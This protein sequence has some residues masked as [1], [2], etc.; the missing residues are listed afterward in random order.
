[1]LLRAVRD[2]VSTSEEPLGEGF[3][4]L[5]AQP[6]RVSATRG[7]PTTEALVL[8]PDALVRV[9]GTDGVP[10]YMRADALPRDATGE[11]DLTRF[12]RG[13]RR[14]LGG[15]L[16]ELLELTPLSDLA[17]DLAVDAAVRVLESRLADRFGL[18]RLPD[19]DSAP[20]APSTWSA[21]R[22]DADA[23]DAPAL[24][25]LH[26]V[27]QLPSQ[28]FGALAGTEAWRALRHRY[29]NR[30]LAYAGA[31][32]T[33]SPVANAIELV[34]RLP[35]RAVIDIVSY[36]RGGLIG[37]LLAAPAAPLNMR[38]L[39]ALAARADARDP[40]W[41]TAIDLLQREL[42]QLHALLRERRVTVRNHFRVATPLLGTPLAGRRLDRW[43]SFALGA[44]GALTPLGADPAY[45]FFKRTALEIVRRKG[46]ASMLPGLAA[47]DPDAPLVRALAQREPPEVRAL[48]RPDA[49]ATRTLAV[50]GDVE[51]GGFLG[52]LA[53]AAA[54]L[55]FGEPNDLVVPTGAMVSAGFQPGS[56]AFETRVTLRDADAHHFGYFAHPG[57][58]K[59]LAQWPTAAEGSTV[60][61]VV[62]FAF[63][64]TLPL[65]KPNNAPEKPAVVIV[66]GI[67]GTSLRVKNENGSSTRVWPDVGSLILGRFADLRL[68]ANDR[69]EVEAPLDAYYG[70]LARALVGDFD[71]HPM[72]YDWR[73]AISDSADDLAARI[74]KDVLDRNPARPVHLVC[75]SMGGVIA[76]AMLR[77]H[78]DLAKA[79]K[80]QGSRLI[81]MGAPSL[82]AVS[83]MRAQLGEDPLVQILAGADLFH[84]LEEI[85]DVLR[86]FTGLAQLRPDA[87]IDSPQWP[88]LLRKLKLPKVVEDATENFELARR[89][90]FDGKTP[91]PLPTFYIYGRGRETLETAELDGKGRVRFK[92][93]PQGDGRV[94]WSAG[95]VGNISKAWWV[96]AEH[97]SIPV[98]VDPL[99]VAE[100]LKTGN[101]GRL[102]E[103]LPEPMGFFDLRGEPGDETAPPATSRL[104]NVEDLLAVA[105]GGVARRSEAAETAVAATPLA[106]K[107]VHGSLHT[108]SDLIVLGVFEGEPP[109]EL[110][111]QLDHVTEGHVLQLWEAKGWPLHTG[112][113]AA[114]RG[115]TAPAAL[116]VNLGRNGTLTRRA[117]VAHMSRA[118]C[119]WALGFATRDPGRPLPSLSVALV[120]ADGTNA[121]GAEEV[122]V[123]LVE[124]V[125]RVNRA[126]ARATPPVTTRVRALSILEPYRDLAS[127]VTVALGRLQDWTTLRLAER[128]VEVEREFRSTE[129][130]FGARPAS[131]GDWETWSQLAVRAREEPGAWRLVVTVGD[132]LAARFQF[133]MRLPDTLRT[134]LMRMATAAADDPRE[135]SA[136]FT[137]A[138][139][140]E[141]REAVR[142][143]NGL[144]LHLDRGSA[145]IPWE[146]LLRG[147][148][149]DGAEPCDAVIRVFQGDRRVADLPP[150]T[151]RRALVVGDPA[152]A[153]NGM[154][155]LP[156]ARFEAD[157]VRTRLR[158]GPGGT[159]E[160][161]GRDGAEA[162]EILAW[163][164]GT[165][166]RFLHL[167][168]HGREVDGRTEIH[169]GGDF[170][171]GAE[172][173][174]RVP[175]L[176][177]FVF[178]NAC[179]SGAAG[180]LTNEPPKLAA[181]L[182]RAFLKRGVRAIVVAGW[183]VE[184]TAA[185]TFAETLYE[186][187]LD[188][189][190]FGRAVTVARART[191][192]EH[193]WVNTWGAYQ[194]YGDPLA[195]L[196]PEARLDRRLRRAADCVSVDDALDAILSLQ[197][198][199]RL[200]RSDRR[201]D[202]CAAVHRL[203]KALPTGVA[204]AAEVQRRLGMLWLELG[205]VRRA[206]MAFSAA[207]LQADRTMIGILEWAADARSRQAALPRTDSR[208]EDFARADELLD[209][210]AK[211]QPGR[212][213]VLGVQAHHALRQGDWMKALERLRETRGLKTATARHHVDA[214]L[215]EIAV[216]PGAVD[217][218]GNLK[219]A[220]EEA[221]K[222]ATEAGSTRDTFTRRAIADHLFLEWLSDENAVAPARVAQ[223]YR[224]LLVGRASRLWLD[225][226]RDFFG[227]LRLAIHGA[228]ARQNALQERLALALDAL[229]DALADSGDVPPPLPSE[230]REGPTVH[231]VVVRHLRPDD[232]A[233][234]KKLLRSEGG[235]GLERI[236]E[237]REAFT[238]GR[239]LPVTILRL[240]DAKLLV[241]DLGPVTALSASKAATPL[242][243]PV[244]LRGARGPLKAWP[245]TFRIEGDWTAIDS[246]AVKVA[247]VGGTLLGRDGPNALLASLRDVG[248]C[249][250]IQGHPGVAGFERQRDE[251]PIVP[252]GEVAGTLRGFATEPST[253]NVVVRTN[254][255]TVGVK[256]AIEATG[257]T[258]LGVGRRV[259]RV[260]ATLERA[261]SV[262]ALHDDIERV[263]AYLLP[264]LVNDVARRLVGI[265]PTGVGVASL[266]PPH[267]LDGSGEV[268]AVADSG[269]DREHP[270]FE[271]SRVD[272]VDRTDTGIDDEVGHGTHVAGTIA[273]SGKA[274]DGQLRGIAP[275]A[276]LVIQKIARGA[277]EEATLVGLPVDLGDLL[278][279][280]A[281]RGATIH[282][283]SWGAL[284]RGDYTGDSVEVDTWLHEEKN[285]GQLLVVAAGN[286]GTTR[287]R[288]N[289]QRFARQGFVEWFS[290]TSPA[291]AK[292][293]LVV[294]ASRS[295]R[296]SGGRSRLSYGTAFPG[297]FPDPPTRDEMVSGAPEE[298]AAFSSR[299]PTTGWQVRPDLVAPGTDV[300]SA[301]STRVPDRDFWGVDKARGAAYWG[302]TSMATPVVAGC[303]A[304]VRQYYREARGVAEPSAALL[305]A[306]LIAGARWLT[307]GSAIA[308]HDRR[309]NI[310]QGFGRVDLANTIPDETF[311]LEFVDTWKDL[312]TP[313]FE[314]PGQRRGYVIRVRPGRPLRVCLAYTDAPGKSVQNDLQLFVLQGDDTFIGNAG[315]TS[316]PFARGIGDFD[317]ANNVKVVVVDAP[318]DG[319]YH[320]H[321]AADSLPFAP[322]HFALVVLGLLDGAIQRI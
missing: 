59:A 37:E 164:G 114:V 315:L 289:T 194:C 303:A 100:I 319:K 65:R 121:L 227:R 254:G 237:T 322:Q 58:R 73:R 306:T 158:T 304:L 280:A 290:V 228:P 13:A 202:L 104:P 246:I 240:R 68:D 276:A 140:R 6:L 24:L 188:G 9:T 74:E 161:H 234:I 298:I 272:P 77:L 159:W 235:V 232:A 286:D 47:M 81:L 167:A 151:A 148:T 320:I 56:S 312:S 258:V 12:A 233:T 291:T 195:V 273:S 196:V 218:M 249:N 248:Q 35:E 88:F 116:L 310:H 142:G 160:V 314:A 245:A 313:R 147:A 174:R 113:W 172:I 307:G 71:V 270:D 153:P 200:L 222:A 26:G 201:G 215:V 155:P 176:P 11:V 250:E 7:G 224:A 253:W 124:A 229:D 268:I 162:G 283:W 31:T 54:D 118:L 267:A 171:E 110:A 175:E 308:D 122:A 79:L 125:L 107:V 300:L 192:R 316:S 203:V 297:V 143:G 287:T 57:L 168:T 27:F 255:D 5:R 210:A 317:R 225:I 78:A 23:T 209:L 45:G 137:A 70:D 36:S 43:L 94:L 14:D 96:K 133:P 39:D 187:I 295:D 18:W 106:V 40:R 90:Q 103:G 25:F 247:E 294:G 182:A 296:T 48:S 213:A 269:L 139:T 211:L 264:E 83:A 214:L 239:A 144:V 123:G 108:A 265:G 17:A 208:Q 293:A 15:V 223:A 22:S 44:L 219:R 299:G 152:L 93:S 212:A 42:T 309:P 321:V 301:R 169:L 242:A 134:R 97:A 262:K 92:T 112:T 271:G 98:F 4:N 285:L 64:L 46:D 62:P 217:L 61:G 259:V 86:S 180:G 275:G 126:L 260:H 51:G 230:S 181:G 131:S 236:D 2:D 252:S 146:I 32:M 177:Q 60:R 76:A 19:A 274:S 91:F 99:A 138:S 205:E 132:R 84:G 127:R 63:G 256:Q 120:G 165:P 170:W 302:G 318:V 149:D 241:E 173:L 292:N 8:A 154:V 288:P 266:K 311:S 193:P 163:L 189:E 190:T 197:G 135:A 281:S 178:L 145:S 105:M 53:A 157:G 89:T 41:R 33:V 101:T 10:L 67:M 95:K 244:T 1:M 3:G 186:Q 66:P 305:K 282:N 251:G 69:V 55:F 119:G 115:E 185:R 150:A 136:V 80:L 72:G 29:P 117:L 263:E 87:L 130:Y 231:R 30:V 221:E 49:G 204:R 279:E 166:Y 261:Q 238:L 38:A 278:G 85:I 284:A 128:E 199:A 207:L 141:L 179:H 16:V 111:H 156:G 34:E 82:G 75:H 21:F 216:D 226:V 28:S 109:G 129:G 20:A 257:I 198:D 206:V 277:G 191:R 220:R 50:A 102:R 52:R 183:A 184:D 243:A